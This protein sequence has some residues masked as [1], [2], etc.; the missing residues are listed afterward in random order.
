MFRI[1]RRGLFLACAASLLLPPDINP[2]R[3]EPAVAVDPNRVVLLSDTHIGDPAEGDERKPMPVANLKEAVSKITEMRP[4]PAA[5]LVTGDCAFLHGQASDY[6]MLRR[7]VAPLSEVG[8][9][10]HFAMGNHDNREAFYAVFPEMEPET[11]LVEG[12]HVTVVSTPKADWIVLDSNKETDYTPGLLGEPQMAWLKTRL[13]SQGEKPAI[14]LAHHNPNPKE[15]GSGLQDMDPFFALAD[16]HPAAKAYL[17][18]HSHF[19]IQAKRE[20]G[21]HLINLPTTAWTFAENTPR[22]FVDTRVDGQGMTMTFHAVGEGDSL[23][24]K[25]YRFDWR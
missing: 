13:E 6:A 17:F 11:P 3:A 8:I 18:G 2:A 19:W 7:L 21:L 12:K 10:I 14:L 15:G 22:G 24:G 23:D 9:P 1:T 20:S 4:R 16:A 5:V 25:E